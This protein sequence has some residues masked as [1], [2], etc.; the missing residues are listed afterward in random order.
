M[1]I[2]YSRKRK[3]KTKIEV[4]PNGLVLGRSGSGKVRMCI[5]PNVLKLTTEKVCNSNSNR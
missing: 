1:C 4:S 5:K 2:F 3:L